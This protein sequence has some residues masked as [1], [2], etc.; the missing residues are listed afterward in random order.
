MIDLSN[1]WNYTLVGFV[2]GTLVGLTGVGGGALMTPILIAVFHIPPSI[3][4]GTDLVNASFTKIVG[5]VQ[6]WRQGTV[7]LRIVGLLALGSVPAAVVGVGVVKT[8]KDAMGP[9]GESVLTVILAWT[10]ILVAIL[11]V[12]RLLVVRRKSADGI[13]PRHMEPRRRDVVTVFLGVVAGFLVSL[14]SVGAGSIIMVFLVAMYLSPAKRLVGT[15]V[16]HAA[17]LA[18]V[19]ALGHIWA[20]DVSFPIAGALLLGSL[21]GVLV[22]SRLTVRMPDVVLRIVLALTLIFS[23]MRLIIR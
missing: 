8:L 9:A 4:I 16:V 21:P 15:D 12:V 18:S 6:H 19:A 14:T 5:A 20:G 2:V 7:K 22:G 13:R 11:M 23:G 10:L 3:A 17:L 1:F